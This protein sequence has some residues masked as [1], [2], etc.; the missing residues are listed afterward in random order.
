MPPTVPTITFNL[1]AREI[2]DF[3]LKKQRVTD[4]G[5]APGAT[6]A[7]TAQR[8]LNMMLKGW[9]KYQNL[10]RLTEGVTSLS[11]NDVDYTLSPVPHRVISARYRNSSG[12]DLPMFLMTRSEYF[13]L[14]NK[15]NA[16]APHSYYVDYQA[17]QAI[18]YIWQPLA[19][20]TTETIQYTY[21]R[22]F[23][24]VV[25]LDDAI[26]VPSECLD[27]VGYNLAHRLGPDFGRCNSSSFK[28]IKEQALVLKE[29]L[30]DDNREEFVRFQP[31]YD[32]MGR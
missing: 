24:D 19:S 28:E 2:I 27:V 14:P 9:Q 15:T 29:E 16:G 17:T 7:A 32:G 31:A 8:E 26:D 10:W 22:K 11:V 13:D 18:L 6:E 21:Q 23:S 4:A 12:N 20:V 1:T 30:L 3:A 5:R 25:V